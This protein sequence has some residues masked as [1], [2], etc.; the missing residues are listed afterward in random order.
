MPELEQLACY[1]AY[2]AFCVRGPLEEK[3]KETSM[4]KVYTEIELPL[5]FTWIPWK[6][7]ESK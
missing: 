6:N 7:G 3:L 2:T 4:W 1:M 5:V